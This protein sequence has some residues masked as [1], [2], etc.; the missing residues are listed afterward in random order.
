MANA[1]LSFA[2]IHIRDP[3]ILTE[4]GKYYLYGSRGRETW[5]VCTGLDV[6]VSDDLL[7]WSEP[8]EVF[9]KP[10]GFWADKNY[11]AP[12][13]HKYKD[14]Y[15]MFVSF[16]TDGVCRGTQILRADSPLGPFLPISDGPITPRDWECLDGTLYIDKKGVPYIVFCHEWVQ[17]TDGQVCALQLT[18]DLTAAVGEPHLLFKASQCPPVTS[19][20]GKGAYVTDGP[21]LHRMSDGKLIM[22]W[23]SFFDDKYCELISYSDN[24][25]INGNWLHD[26]IPLFSSDGGHGMIFKDNDGQLCFIMHKPN[27]WPDER[28]VISHLR[29]EN[30]TL[31]LDNH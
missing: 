14:R 24:G 9:T 21:Y 28:P 31:V 7:H 27:T 20:D 18:D 11:W 30:H 3:F 12:E 4:N 16:K 25:D 2:D 19:Y 5:D 8:V 26:D 1:P 23:S 10:E 13:V 15:Y 17:V 6:F 29:E 22:I